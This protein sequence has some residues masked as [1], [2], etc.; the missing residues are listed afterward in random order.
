MAQDNSDELRAAELIL[1][2][3]A[4]KVNRHEFEDS[5][6]AAYDQLI[7]KFGK[8]TGRHGF[9]INNHNN[10]SPMELAVSYK[11]RD[12]LVSFDQDTHTILTILNGP[13][14]TT[15]AALVE[16]DPLEKIYR[17]SDREEARPDAKEGELPPWRSALECLT[18]TV[19]LQFE[20]AIGV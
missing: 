15:R 18:E 6:I 17:G 20:D 19:C 14:P 7:N 1:L 2:R 3:T 4:Y 10:K 16:Y 13:N 11:R 9:V 12:V 5:V 8:L